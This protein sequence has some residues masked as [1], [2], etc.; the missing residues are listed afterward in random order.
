ML[1]S[2]FA[3]YKNTMQAYSHAVADK[4]KFFSYGD[5][6]FI[7]KNEDAIIQKPT[8]AISNEN[9]TDILQKQE[10]IPHEI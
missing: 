10:V 9:D 5:C 4:Y 7:T 2:A 8:P 3:G 1:V 6:M